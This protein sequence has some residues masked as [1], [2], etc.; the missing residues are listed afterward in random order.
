MSP[1]ISVRIDSEYDEL[2][3]IVSQLSIVLLTHQ[4]IRYLRQELY[5]PSR[6]YC[7]TK[8]CLLY[9]LTIH[10]AK[11]HKSLKQCRWSSDL[12]TIYACLVHEK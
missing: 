4:E 9:Q 2:F 11:S 6:R 10:Y 5:A 12:A 7:D 8:H 3:S 1:E